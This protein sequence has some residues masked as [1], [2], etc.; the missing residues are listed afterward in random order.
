MLKKVPNWDSKV[1]INGI[2]NYPF[3]HA[4]IKEINYN[5]DTKIVDI[6]IKNK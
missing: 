4:N 6:I 2:L 1:R 5:L 3:Q